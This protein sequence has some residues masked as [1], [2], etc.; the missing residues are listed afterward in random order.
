MSWYA[1]LQLKE[2]KKTLQ[3]FLITSCADMLGLGVIKMEQLV[4]RD[5]VNKNLPINLTAFEERQETKDFIKFI[6]LFSC[7]Y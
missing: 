3:F 4:K 6:K 1:A 5:L 2:K 7:V